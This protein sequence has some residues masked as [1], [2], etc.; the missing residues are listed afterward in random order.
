M[1]LYL[2]KNENGVTVVLIT[3]IFILSLVN[4]NSAEIPY[5]DEH[6][7]P[8]KLASDLRGKI[9]MLSNEEKIPVIIFLDEKDVELKEIKEI[10]RLKRKYKL[11]DAISAELDKGEIEDLKDNPH[12]KKIY[13]DRV[14][15]AL[16]IRNDKKIKIS[17]SAETIGAY[18]VQDHLNYTGRNIT[19][20]VIDTGIDYTHPDLGGYF[21][22]GYK[23]KD[24]YDFI[25]E[26]S[27]PMDDNG[28]GT[29]CAGIVAAN[30]NIKGIAPDADLL[31]VKVLDSEGRGN[32][33]DVLAGIDWAV[34][35]G[36]DIISLSLGWNEQPNDGMEPLDLIVNAA[37][38]KG[39][40]V[41]A[42]AGN[43]G[44]G[45]GAI[46][47]PASA[48][49]VISVGA[50]DD[51]GT[52]NTDDDI[53][54]D[55]SCR[56]PSAFGRFDPDVV[57][58]GVGIYSTVPSASCEL[59]DPSGYKSL[60]GT[61]MATPHVAGAAA[62][63]LEYNRNLTPIMIKSL[64][65]HSA[66]GITGHPFEAGAGLINITRAI[67]SGTEVLI[68]NDD[69]W[70]ESIIAGMNT[71]AVLKIK[72]NHEYSMNFSISISSLTDI[73][74]DYSIP[75]TWFEFPE[76]IVLEPSEEKEV[77]IKFSAHPEANPGTY[78][79]ILKIESNNSEGIRIPIAITIPLFDTGTIQGI[80]DDECSI[81]S[82]YSCG[83]D[84]S[85]SVDRWGDWKFYQIKN[86]NGTSI[87]IT[88]NWSDSSNDLDLYLFAP[89]GV[90]VDVSGEG[91]TT[92]EHILLSN[93]VY[94]EYWVAVYAY[95]VIP[96]KLHFNLTVS[97]LSSLRVE[98]SSW[99]GSASKGETKEIEFYLTNN[100]ATKTNLHLNINILQ[101]GDTHSWHFNNQIP[102]SFCTYQWLR[103]DL[104]MDTSKT[105]YITVN[106][107]WN[108][109][110]DLNLILAYWNDDGDHIFQDNEHYATRFSS[111]H[112]NHQ[113]QEYWER[114]E[115][116]DIQHYLKNYYD[117]GV[118]VCNEDIIKFQGSFNVDVQLYDTSP[119]S[120]AQVIPN[121]IPILN[122]Y[123]SKNLSVLI[124]TNS[125]N[126]NKTYDSFLL[127]K[128]NSDLA[129]VPIRLSI[130]ATSSTT[131]T[132]TTTTTTIWPCDL[133]G[134]YPTCGEVTL[135]EVVDFI[136]LW[137]QGQAELEDVVNLINA[138]AG[139]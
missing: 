54:A 83:S 37:V 31:A 131:T 109:D 63:L 115:Y 136:N 30:G 112:D 80:V 64:L 106:L 68:N 7:N 16:P 26:D 48:E 74:G 17:T 98:P 138:W 72:N 40:V 47:Y 95:D 90:L 1:N 87:E 123:Q 101:D 45:T 65:I 20:A 114:I 111:T 27:D 11:I 86:H 52:V 38:E 9:K 14:I 24:G 41:V 28:H 69:C 103:T 81:D 5:K 25:N 46:A 104:G 22:E 128:E 62:L 119:W 43:E 71:T 8:G 10:N 127:I 102:P 93:P 51:R 82:P 139:S 49:K 36:A 29:H 42:A 60:Q 132:T 21:G 79:S 124:D 66:G 57:A 53:V 125:L 44:P 113:L 15:H 105:R 13:Y 107:S 121:S 61:S 89:N 126:E 76:S 56:G 2:Q 6:Q 55:F 96:S 97:Y 99:Q 77:Q 12:V 34:A 91:N 100:A 18:Y 67:E 78:G 134:D 84:P 3:V 59:C 129:K 88:L 35:N 73:E 19:V 33:S 133:P 110:R 137:A 75:E 85:D 94:H 130:T 108:T 116:V 70:E 118:Y 50:S 4:S 92:G 58:P 117:V 120:V 23:V 135:E 122:P 32:I 39:I